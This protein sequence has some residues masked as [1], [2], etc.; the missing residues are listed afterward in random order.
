MGSL[1]DDWIADKDP[2][3]KQRIEFPRDPFITGSRIYGS[4]TE[5]SDL[6]MVIIAREHEWDFLVDS[7]GGKFP[8]R[9]GKLN[10]ILCRNNREYDSWK[11]ARDLCIKR[12][13]KIGRPLTKDEAC[14]IHDMV[15]EKNGTDIGDASG[16]P[17]GEDMPRR[18]YRG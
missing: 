15:H 17:E 2:K 4:P 11:E 14:L 3:E 9:Y 5:D 13:N 18:T 12:K 16:K 8:V 10:L 6:D 7:Q 1:F